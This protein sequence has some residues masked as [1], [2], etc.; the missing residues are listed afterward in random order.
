M[1]IEKTLTKIIIWA[2]ANGIE[3]TV[4]K[5]KAPVGQR[6]M[7]EIELNKN[8][9]KELVRLY[10]WEEIDAPWLQRMIENA[11]LNLSLTRLVL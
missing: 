4:R 11:A 9:K 1:E 8:G 3:I 5:F 2:F 6:N 10:D 7:I